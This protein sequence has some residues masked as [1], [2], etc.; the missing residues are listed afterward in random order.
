VEAGESY[1]GYIPTSM[2]AALG[3]SGK[4]RAT[5]DFTACQTWHHQHPRAHSAAQDQGSGHELH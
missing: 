5:T 4:L 1:I 3:G 2:L